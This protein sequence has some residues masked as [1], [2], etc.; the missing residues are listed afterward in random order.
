MNKERIRNVEQKV[1]EAI[2]MYKRNY[3][4]CY[5]VYA[6]EIDS[7]RTETITAIH[8]YVRQLKVIGSLKVED[9]LSESLAAAEEVFKI[10]EAQ[11]LKGD[12]KSSFAPQN[13]FLGIVEIYWIQEFILNIRDNVGNQD[14]TQVKNSTIE[15]HSIPSDFNPNDSMEEA[16]RKCRIH[17]QNIYRRY[18]T[19]LENGKKTLTNLVTTL[20]KASNNPLSIQEYEKLERQL[21]QVKSG[22]LLGLN[23]D[24]DLGCIIDK[25]HNSHIEKIFKKLTDFWNNSTSAIDQHLKTLNGL[26]KRD[27]LAQLASNTNINS[28]SVNIGSKVSSIKSIQFTNLETIQKLFPLLKVFFENKEDELFKALNGEHLDEPILFPH[29][30][31]KFVEVFKRLKYNGF[32]LSSST[33]L[34]DWICSN[35]SYRFKKGKTVEN[36]RFNKSTVWDILSKDIEVTKK[37]RICEVDWLPYKSLKKRREEM[38]NEKQKK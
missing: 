21:N 12:L 22:F 29:N 20:L 15:F 24:I 17:N 10:G 14:T 23:E 9:E 18:E 33:E 36:R 8:S 7:K 35:F 25:Q 19:N 27:E 26:K 16:I 1:D 6:K 37:E 3:P 11:L 30:Q 2:Q 4:E 34:R 5:N 31:N 32:I 38:D 28:A 13:I